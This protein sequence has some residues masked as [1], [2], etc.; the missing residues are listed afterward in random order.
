M[1]AGRR[2]AGRGRG[3][4]DQLGFPQ[5]FGELGDFVGGGLGGDLPDPGDLL[6]L[7]QLGQL[8][9]QRGV[10]IYPVVDLG[11]GRGTSL[12]LVLAVAQRGDHC[13][14]LPRGTAGRG[15]I[16][17]VLGVDP[18]DEQWLGA[19]QRSGV[20]RCDIECPGQRVTTRQ[21]HCRRR[22]CLQHPLGMPQ[23]GVHG[24]GQHGLHAVVRLVTAVLFAAW[25]KHRQLRLSPLVEALAVN[26]TIRARAD[27]GGDLGSD[28]GVRRLDLLDFLLRRTVLGFQ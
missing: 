24:L 19:R 17:R 6:V 20:A 12:H 4:S 5:L 16:A 3:G 21:I 25:L 23:L 28:V 1:R 27:L 2:G 13:R 11:D 10:P 7:R 22:R 9:G 18:L 26:E 8:S 15:E 14:P